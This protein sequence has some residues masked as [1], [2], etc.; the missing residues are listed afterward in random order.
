MGCA[1]SRFQRMPEEKKVIVDINEIDLQG[2]RNDKFEARIPIRL[3]EVKE[4]CKAIR[5][6]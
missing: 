4:Y 1:K 6:L 5:E 2:T 3:T